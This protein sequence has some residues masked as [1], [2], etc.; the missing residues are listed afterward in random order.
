LYDINS[1]FSK[2]SIRKLPEL[3][4]RLGEVERLIGWSR[5]RPIINDMYHD[6]PLRGG[7]PHIDEII[8]IKLLI[9][10]QWYGLSDYELERQALDRVSFLNFLGR[11]ESIPDRSTIWFSGTI[12]KKPQGKFDLE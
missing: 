12:D 4:D 8:L 3:G 9:L 5:F 1:L 10:Q 11:P 2:S 7:R 6:D